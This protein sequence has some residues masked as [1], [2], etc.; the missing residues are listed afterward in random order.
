MQIF[1][2][3]NNGDHRK[4]EKISNRKS[5]LKKRVLPGKFSRALRGKTK[6]LCHAKAQ[7]QK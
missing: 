2:S 4:G 7:S 1:I 5:L 3:F 6:E